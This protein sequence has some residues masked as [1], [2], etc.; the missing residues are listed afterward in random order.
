MSQQQSASQSTSND[1]QG[2]KKFFDLHT[3]GIGYLNRV[4]MV[5]TKGKGGRRGDSFL[6]C[7][8]N[9]LHGD[10]EDPNTSLFDCRVSGKEAQDIVQALL[11]EVTANKKV[12]I[13][14]CIGDTYAHTY[15]RKV[16]VRD[17]NNQWKETGET[18]TTALI[19]GRLL[20]ITY[21]KVDGE[22][23]YRIDEDGLVQ[24][25]LK[26]PESTEDQSSDEDNHSRTGTHG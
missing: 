1:A 22:V 5:T 15:E 8:V 7:A 4:R 24:T 13:A 2:E 19:K 20:Q 6:A 21:A 16:K 11:P 23:V 14:F 18:E 17:A 26:L 12:I 9:A 10:S 3:R 25:S